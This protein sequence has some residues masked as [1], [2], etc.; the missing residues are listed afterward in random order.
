MSCT[1]RCRVRGVVRLC[2]WPSSCA[3]AALPGCENYGYDGN[4]DLCTDSS[5][6]PLMAVVF[7]CSFII[8]SSMMILNLFIGVITSSMQDA[9]TELSADLEED[10][11]KDEDEIMMKRLQELY[12]I[13]NEASEEI[14]ELASLE[15]ERSQS[16]VVQLSRSKL[17]NNKE[18]ATDSPHSGGA[19]GSPTKM[20]AT[21]KRAG[22]AGDVKTP[23]AMPAAQPHGSESPT[24]SPASD[25][26]GEMPEPRTLAP[27]FGAANLN[28]LSPVKENIGPSERF[29]TS[30]EADE[31]LRDAGFSQHE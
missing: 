8:L 25:T 1:S 20:A 15:K 10:E 7:H 5:A 3:H 26:S 29:M 11:E 21:P 4:E 31:L 6:S 22:G 18:M 14:T 2:N 27:T 24:A 16:A 9:K 28:V 30:Q 23:A 13:M 17:L 19:G 12:D